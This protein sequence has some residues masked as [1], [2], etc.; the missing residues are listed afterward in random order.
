MG[1]LTDSFFITA[2]RSNTELVAQLP[3]GDF[4]N[5]VAYPDADMENVQLPYIIVNNDGGNNVEETKDDKFEGT[6]DSVAISIRVVAR[7]RQ[8]LADMVLAVRKTVHDYVLAATERNEAGTGT[9]D[10][11]LC[12][13]DYNFSFS[14]VANDMQK[15]SFTQILNY[16]CRTSNDIFDD[17]D[18]E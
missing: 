3:A 11:N 10:D 9:G 13:E 7:S 4:Y 17:D 18:N 15:P 2:L 6:V 16:Q 8:E 12:P 14:E 5:N 1:L